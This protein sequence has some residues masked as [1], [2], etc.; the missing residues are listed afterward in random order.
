MMGFIMSLHFGDDLNSDVA[1]AA[2]GAGNDIE[3]QYSIFSLF[4]PSDIAKNHRSATFLK[5]FIKGIF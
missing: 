1:P 5:K 2:W 4:F 3:E